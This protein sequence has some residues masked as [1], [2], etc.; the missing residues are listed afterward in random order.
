MVKFFGDSGDPVVF[1]PAR[2]QIDEG[3]QVCPNFI[4]PKPCLKGWKTLCPHMFQDVGE[5]LLPFV[6]CLCGFLA[7]PSLCGCIGC[8]GRQANDSEC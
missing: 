8:P 6:T 7:N 5:E 4:A 1:V 3:S 2:V